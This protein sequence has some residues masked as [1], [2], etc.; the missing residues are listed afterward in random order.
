MSKPMTIALTSHKGGTGKTTITW[1]LS[2]ALARKGFRVLMV[3][4]DEQGN[5][6]QSM[7]CKNPVKQVAKM[8]RDFRNKGQTNITPELSWNETLLRNVKPN[9]DLLPGGEY[10]NEHE[11]MLSADRG[12]EKVLRHALDGYAQEYDFVFIDCPPTKQVMA[13]I[14]LAAAT[15][16]IV[17]I[18]G[19]NFAYQGLSSIYKLVNRVKEDYNPTL[20]LAGV[21]LNRYRENT[22]F[23]R[24][25]LAELENAAEI[26][27]F[28]TRIRQSISLMEATA[29]DKTIFEYDPESNGAVDFIALARELCN[30]LDYHIP[31]GGKPTN[32]P[33]APALS[34]NV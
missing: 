11:L 15:H 8:L 13:Y 19:E 22:V 32:E 29:V 33:S 10:I 20:K 24:E 26:T 9:L 6:S 1:G 23:G 4:L 12:V 17:P 25:I 2:T 21:I 30:Q 18:Q 5:L 16:Y 31:K 28:E 7:G 3:D 34:K 27:V 14:S